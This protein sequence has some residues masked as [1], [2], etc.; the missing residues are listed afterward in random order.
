MSECSEE[1]RW[2]TVAEAAE[3]LRVTT[4]TIYNY[5]KSGKLP[6]YHLASKHRRIKKSDLDALF[7][8]GNPDE[9]HDTPSD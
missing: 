7:E 6:F 8:L 5:M 9:L 1:N 4:A 3:Y 2:Y